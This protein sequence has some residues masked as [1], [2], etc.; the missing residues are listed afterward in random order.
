VTTDLILLTDSDKRQTRPLVREGTLRV[1]NIWLWAPDGTRHQER[2]T[3]W[4]TDRQSH[5]DSD[6]DASRIHEYACIKR[7]PSLLVP[8]RYRLCKRLPVPVPPAL[9]SH[10]S[11]LNSSVAIPLRQTA[12]HG[13]GSP[14]S[15]SCHARQTTSRPHRYHLPAT[16]AAPTGSHS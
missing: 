8:Y 14:A 12:S 13:R 5:S 7:A 10:S 9:S 2:Q 3:D 11:A 1:T 6:S 15:P 16:T 4:L